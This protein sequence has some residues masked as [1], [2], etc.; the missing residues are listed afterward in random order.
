[1]E[2]KLKRDIHS[3]MP[4]E[5]QFRE[6][7]QFRNRVGMAWR[8]F[9]YFSLGLALVVLIV[10]VTNV[11]NSAFGAIASSYEIDPKSLS[12]DGRPLEDLS[13][14]ELMAILLE[15]S[16]NKMAVFVRDRLSVVPQDAYTES[17]LSEVLPNGNYPEG[18]AD[19]TINEIRALDNAPEILG[20]FFLLNVGREDI[21]TLILEDIVK[22]QV[23]E[24][25]TLY[26]SIFN[27]D[28]ILASVEANYPDA[29]L[30]RYHSW[31]SQRFIQTPMSS[32][33]FN[34]GIRTALLGSLLLMLIVIAVSLPVGVG[35]AVYLEEYAKDN[36]LASIP[37][38]LKQMMENWPLPRII[39]RLIVRATDL[40]YIIEIN[41]RNLAGV[42][43]IIYGILGL[44]IFVRL[45]APVT[46]GVAFGINV[47]V[48]EDSR[49]IDLIDNALPVTY[50]LN[51]DGMITGLEDNPL[52]TQTQ[53]LEL[54][55]TF[56]YFG[57]PSLVNTGNLSPSQAETEI[58]KVLGLNIVS[59]IPANA[60]ELAYTPLA[61]GYINLS[62]STISAEQFSALV[63]QLQSITAFTVN[64]RTVLSAALTLGLLI[65]PII[66]INSQEAL[67]AVPNPLREASYGLGATK[68][69]TI[70]RTVLPASIP[71]IMTGTIL[72]VSRA[73]GETAPLIVVGASTFLLSDPSGPFSKFTVLPIQIYNWTSRPQ[74]QFQ[75]IAA[76]AIIVLL[77]MVLVLNAAAIILRNRY[78]QRF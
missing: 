13:E 42:P 4:D 57:T 44:A 26:D 12:A 15:H 18:F 49:I 45:F 41:V 14:E 6:R 46:S 70:W 60:D 77:V 65:L 58:A 37:K 71:G 75:S 74:V 22:L 34:A 2:E 69:Q 72:A 7:L 50:T 10:L 31:L 29:V 24:S 56:R 16:G 36:V 73:V 53:A 62:E 64:G 3:I 35:A 20:Q 55:R 78:S 25:W 67:R 21:E 28:E 5:K 32:E 47:S 61:S 38:R 48:P 11:S 76:A 8:G 43:S 54:S 1:M 59:A 52:L 30:T 40:N 66:I 9:Y 39:K 23:L 33:P 68:W 19:T 63:T 17:T 51:E 27:Y